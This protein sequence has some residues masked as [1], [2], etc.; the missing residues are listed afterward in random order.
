VEEEAEY[1]YCV[2]P[3]PFGSENVPLGMEIKGCI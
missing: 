2:D 3:V 1:S